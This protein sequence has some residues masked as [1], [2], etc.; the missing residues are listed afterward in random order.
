MCRNLIATDLADSMAPVLSK[1]KGGQEGQGSEGSGQVRTDSK[2]HQEQ[3]PR[4]KS[5][6]KW[7]ASPRKTIISGMPINFYGESFSFFG[8]QNIE[9]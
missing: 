2:V 7:I 6:F 9:F 8:K 5:P 1:P 4:I 3:N